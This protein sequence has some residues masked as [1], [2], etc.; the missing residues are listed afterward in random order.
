[1]TKS[2]PSARPA[3]PP[4]TFAPSPASN[5]SKALKDEMIL[6]HSRFV[7][8]PADAYLFFSD[9]NETDSVIKESVTLAKSKD[10][11]QDKL[12]AISLLQRHK[13]LQD[14]IQSFE[15]DIARVE[16]NGQKLMN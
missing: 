6:R 14:K 9:C 10:F 13:H 16:E 4:R 8:G 2:L 11:G 12:T 5:R 7:S 15:G 3:A 1:M